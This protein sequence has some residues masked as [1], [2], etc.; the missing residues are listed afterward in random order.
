M[1]TKGILG[2]FAGLAFGLIIGGIVGAILK[3][4]FGIPFFVVWI[5]TIFLFGLWGAKSKLK[6]KKKPSYK[7]CC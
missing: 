6:R 7:I 1:I 3:I 4:S 2:I 5:L